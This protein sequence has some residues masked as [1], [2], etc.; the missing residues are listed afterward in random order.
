MD[1]T[2]GI[3]CYR[4]QDYYCL[5]TNLPPEQD[6]PLKGFRIWQQE[7]DQK[8]EE[9]LLYVL[10]SD[11]SPA[12][13]ES[14][15]KE[16]TAKWKN[17]VQIG[18]SLPLPKPLYNH[19]RI[20]LPEESDL[21]TLINRLQEIFQEFFSFR[22]RIEAMVYRH[23]SYHILLNE[24]EQTYGLLGIL[25]DKNLHYLALSASYATNNAWIVDDSQTLPLDMLN[26]LMLDENFRRAILHKKAFLYRSDLGNQSICAYCYNLQAKN[27]YQA[28][29]L[30]QKPDQQTFYGGYTF[31]EYLGNQLREIW[32]YRNREEQQKRELYDFF[33]TLED[34]LSNIPRNRQEIR[35]SLS[36]RNWKLEDTYQILS[37]QFIE[38]EN[39]TVTRKY[40][41][42]QMESLFADCAILMIDNSMCC[43]R[44]LSLTPETNRDIRQK[45]SV[46]LRENLCKSGISQTFC[47]LSRLA[48]YYQ[49]AKKALLLGQES[50]STQWYYTFEE[51]ILP[52]IWEQ[53][54]RELEEKQLYHPALVTLLAYDHK[55][56]TEMVKTVYY[57]M[58][59]RYN[60]THAAA[61]LFI[62][63]T[64]ML[65]RLQRIDIL[66]GI[67]WDSWE[68][69][70]HLAITLELM[71][72][73]GELTAV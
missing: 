20:S 1:I 8:P 69:R 36:S 5:Q 53:A 33:K 62:H 24:L 54:T 57:Y 64:T 48:V 43:I 12:F 25:V 18:F 10:P 31:A 27:A 67:N 51:L 6:F 2:A 55:E 16:E 14:P 50:K 68:E 63:R 52:Y 30:L 56:Q 35:Q 46:F 17:T 38:E 66:T 11:C 59:C 39:A 49:E 40:Y 44:N 21:T 58:H 26:E 42:N 29:L 61:A 45:L 32:L 13:K 28:R 7:K 34:L 72:K 19:Y 22:S 65:F 3:L 37:F 4:L 41:Q 15:E 23:D 70:L 9:G 71:K 60:V 47:D 73:N